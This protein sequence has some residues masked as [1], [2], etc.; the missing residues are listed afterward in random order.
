MFD[1]TLC[2]MAIDLLGAVAVVQ[3]TQ[4]GANLVEQTWAFWRLGI[5]TA[6]Q[7]CWASGMVGRN[8]HPA[9]LRL[10]KNI[11]N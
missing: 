8:R 10:H 11:S 2:P 9:S 7:I 6:L 4:S 5:R 1:E 3:H